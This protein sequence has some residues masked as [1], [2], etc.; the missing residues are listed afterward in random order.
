MVTN[1]FYIIETILIVFAIFFLG[2]F[3][4]PIYSLF[5][6][7][8]VVFLV[9]LSLLAINIYYL[10]LVFIIIYGGA[11]IILFIMLLLITNKDFYTSSVNIL[12]LPND[13]ILSSYLFLN[14]LFYKII[15][16][17]TLFKKYPIKDL[18]PEDSFKFYLKYQSNDLYIFSE[19][20]FNKFFLFSL[21]VIFV[22]LFALIAAIILAKKT[23]VDIKFYEIPIKRVPFDPNNF[24]NFD[25]SKYENK[26]GS[27]FKKSD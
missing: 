22:M 5:C 24:L 14:I 12:K 17:S 10:S 20:L 3:N 16:S 7:L 1:I 4:N 23:F 15:N 19:H 8:L 6:L 27:S 2:L 26:D 9:A 18:E 13:Y 21:L 11:I 25:A